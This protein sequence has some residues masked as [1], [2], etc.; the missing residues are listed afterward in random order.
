[1]A[2]FRRGS[3]VENLSI[4]EDFGEALTAFRRERPGVENLSVLGVGYLFP[5]RSH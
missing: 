3:G 1:M 4:C 2:K 5:T